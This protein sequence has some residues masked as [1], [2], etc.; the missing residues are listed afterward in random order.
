LKASN[1][2]RRAG[3]CPV[4]DLLEGCRDLLVVIA[5]Q[6][7]LGRSWAS[8][9]GEY[10]FDFCSLLTALGLLFLAAV[11]EFL[12]AVMAAV[13]LDSRRCCNGGPCTCCKCGFCSL[14]CFDDGFFHFSELT[15]NVGHVV[16]D[17]F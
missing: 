7:V 14:G 9:S 16:L 17:C 1:L 12:F 4:G 2:D 15:F 3:G 6:F 10:D 8:L 5:V 11:I 13:G